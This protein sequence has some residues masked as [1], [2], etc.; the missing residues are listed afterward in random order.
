MFLI[1]FIPTQILFAS[2]SITSPTREP[3]PFSSQTTFKPML[4]EKQD[5]PS[6]RLKSLSRLIELQIN[7]IHKHT[8]MI[9][10]FKGHLEQGCRPEFATLLQKHH[11]LLT[12]TNGKDC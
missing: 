9:N 5:A 8:L 3:S 2:P 6:C 10:T 4:L 7:V 11:D 1:K 12:V